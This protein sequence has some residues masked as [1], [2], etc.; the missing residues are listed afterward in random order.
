[1][2]FEDSKGKFPAPLGDYFFNRKELVMNMIRDK[3]EVFPS[4]SGDY[5]LTLHKM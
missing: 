2:L 1:M 4:P 3:F 5:F